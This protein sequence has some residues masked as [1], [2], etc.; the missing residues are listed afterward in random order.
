MY[1]RLVEKLIYLSHTR[2]YV[3]FIVSLVSQFMHLQKEIYLQ[4]ALRIVQY[5][6]GT[7]GRGIMFELNGSVNLE[8]YADADYP[9]LVMD[10]RSTTRYCTFLGRDLLTW[11][12]KKQSVVPRYNA[13]AE[14][15]A[16]TQGI[17]ELL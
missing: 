9:G 5:L 10:K 8:A 15:K 7:S 16:M 12:S 11:K 4:F 13:E 17:C 3:D 2:P 6:K 1:Q 14:F